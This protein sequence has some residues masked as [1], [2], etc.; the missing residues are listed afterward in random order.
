MRYAQD[1]TQ[2]GYLSGLDRR[3]RRERTFRIAGE[4]IAGVVVFGLAMVAVVG[5]MVAI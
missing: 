1:I 5:L 3:L 4:V 2:R